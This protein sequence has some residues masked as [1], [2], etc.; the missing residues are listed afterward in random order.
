MDKW[1]QEVCWAERDA[2][3]AMRAACGLL[4]RICRGWPVL[5]ISFVPF[6]SLAFAKLHPMLAAA[7]TLAVTV[8]AVL[9]V[10]D[11]LLSRS[12]ARHGRS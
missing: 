6:G 5:T 3:E 11:L 9:V 7:C 8:V 12:E 10:D 2:Q 1:D 4:G